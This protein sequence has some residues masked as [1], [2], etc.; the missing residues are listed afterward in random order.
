M[1]KTASTMLPLGTRAPDFRL[2]GV[3]GRE[4]SLSDY[5]GAP[6][7]LVIFMCNHCPFVKHVAP[8]LV[9]LHD[10]Y[11]NKGVVMVGI[12]SN[13]VQAYPQDNLENMQK[14]A[15][16]Q[17]YE[18][19]Y[20]IDESQSVAKAYKAACT[21]DFYLFD[22][23]QRLVYRGQLDDSRPQSSKPLTGIDLRNAIDHLLAGQEVPSDQK[24][25]IGCNIK[26]KPSQEPE[27]F[28][29]AGVG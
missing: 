23:K 16:A 1:V 8:E 22:S 4:V 26:W 18:F 10:D 13:D 15:I 14:E 6:A 3:D 7:L 12:S 9:R 11:A 28:N 21:P 19:P 24:P 25:S 29:P 27:Y 20:L 17:G 5:A 2:P